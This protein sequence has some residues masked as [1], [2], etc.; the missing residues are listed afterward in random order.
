MIYHK[1][2]GIFRLWAEEIEI[3][4]LNGDTSSPCEK[5]YRMVYDAWQNGLP[6]HVTSSV[7]SK[8]GWIS[9]NPKLFDKELYQRS[10]EILDACGIEHDLS[11]LITRT[12]LELTKSKFAKNPVV[13]SPD[14]LISFIK[15]AMA[16]ENEHQKKLIEKAKITNR[17]YQL[18]EQAGINL[19]A[20]YMTYQAASPLTYHKEEAEYNNYVA[21]L[22][23]SYNPETDTLEL[24]NV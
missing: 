5:A 12:W 20:M 3:D 11:K 18:A 2:N 13:Y 24:N 22:I 10:Q 21:R 19:Q 23:N 16:E 1:V 14:E 8:N 9:S 15:T 6:D 7:S 17:V 4:L